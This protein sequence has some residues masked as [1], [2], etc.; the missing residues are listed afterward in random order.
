MFWDTLI[1]KNLACAMI[2]VDQQ[3]KTHKILIIKKINKQH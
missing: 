1:A 3:Q 2:G